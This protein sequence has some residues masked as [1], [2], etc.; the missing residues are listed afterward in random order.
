MCDCMYGHPGKCEICT[1]TYVSVMY[2]RHY[3]NDIF[4]ENSCEKR[5]GLTFVETLVLL[6][7][8]LETMN[9]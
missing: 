1:L 6:F 2:S 5:G 4:K 9:V 3:A 8:K 7:V